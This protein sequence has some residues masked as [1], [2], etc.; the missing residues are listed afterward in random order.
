M[1]TCKICGKKLNRNNRSGYCQLH[2]NYRAER[3]AE[4]ISP[5]KEDRERGY[6]NAKPRTCLKCGNEFPSRGPEN[7]ICDRCKWH[8]KFD[9]YEG[10][11]VSIPEKINKMF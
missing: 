1:L 9:R 10:P 6:R 3:R 8:K 4:L 7:R 11:R 2:A 5:V